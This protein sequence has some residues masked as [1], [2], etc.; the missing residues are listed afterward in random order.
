MHILSAAILY[1]LC[2]AANSFA[3]TISTQR[4]LSF[5]SIVRP[6]PGS[7]PGSVIVTTDG[8]R[9][10]SGVGLSTAAPTAQSA[11]FTI[12]GNAN[13]SLTFKIE[14][15]GHSSGSSGLNASDLNN[16]IINSSSNGVCSQA[17]SIGCAMTIGGSNIT[18]T[19]GA[20][21]SNIEYPLE[22]GN[23]NFTYDI[24]LTY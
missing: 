14:N 7:A 19:M 21:L 20:T 17:T 24:V 15:I 18:I 13:Q 2:S 22:I 3:L 12:N 4:D 23:H 1:I 5:G 6:L 9:A 8:T 11:A 16:I 10:T